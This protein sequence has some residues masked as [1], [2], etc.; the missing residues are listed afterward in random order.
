MAGVLNHEKDARHTI[1]VRATDE[2]GL[3]KV[4]RYDV[5]ILDINDRPTVRVN[6]FFS[7]LVDNMKTA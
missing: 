2:H 7:S 5:N 3:F 1:I 4:V 6:I